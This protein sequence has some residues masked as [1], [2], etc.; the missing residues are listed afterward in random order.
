MTLAVHS[1]DGAVLIDRSDILNLAWTLD[2]R[3]WLGCDLP[4]LI[5]QRL[6]TEV[7]QGFPVVSSY[8]VDD[9]YGERSLKSSV[10]RYFGLAEN[11][12]AVTCG[13]GVNSLLQAAS[14]FGAGAQAGVL[15]DVYPDFPHWASHWGAECKPDLPRASVVLLERPDLTGRTLTH[16]QVRALCAEAAAVDGVVV[17]DESYGNYYDPDFSVASQVPAC[18]NLAVMRGLAKAYWMGGL[19]LG[20]CISSRELAIRLRE[21]LA[22]MGVGSLSLRIGQAVLD[23]GPMAGPLR[24][25]VHTTQAQMTTALKTAGFPLPLT[26]S[27]G[28]PYVFCSDEGGVAVDWLRDRGILVKRQPFWERSRIGVNYKVRMSVPLR[29]ERMQRFLLCLRGGG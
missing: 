20:Y 11:S 19:R 28:V 18:P 22:P 6:A 10:T 3:E 24:T 29:E 27:C 23:L 17:V 12:V 4:A 21:H 15:G 8:L 9:P 1:Y 13:A 16:G 14:H 7:E 25:R 5:A 2:E 26:P